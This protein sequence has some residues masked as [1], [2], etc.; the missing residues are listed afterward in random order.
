MTACAP[1]TVVNWA[2]A[3]FGADRLAD[4][5]AAASR[6]RARVLYALAETD[7]L[8]P[9][10][11]A[12]SFAAAQRRRDPSAYIDTLRLPPGDILFEHGFVSAAG[13]QEFHDREQRLVA[14]LTIGGVN[15]PARAGVGVVG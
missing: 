1:A 6:V 12:T 5:S 7:P 3:A 11:Q 10:A 9:F 2:T 15:P 13:L 4:V 8:I 14:P